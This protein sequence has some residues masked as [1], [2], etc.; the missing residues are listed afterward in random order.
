MFGHRSFLI[1]GGGSPADIKSLTEGGYE[2]LD[3]DFDFHQDIDRN[4]KATTRVYSGTFNIKLSQLPIKEHIEWALDSRKYSDGMIVMLDAD[5][6]PIEKTLFKNATCIQFGIDYT[7][8]GDSYIC[9]K[10]IIHAEKVVVG[11]GIEFENE[12]IYD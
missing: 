9:T 6:I 10:M 11:N 2:I 7:L 4:G 12:W 1:I 3:C 8:S 5:N